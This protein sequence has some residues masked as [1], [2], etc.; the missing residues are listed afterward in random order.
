[1]A[2]QIEIQYNGV[3]Q[4]D[5]DTR[6]ENPLVIGSSA[7][8]DLIETVSVSVYFTSPTYYLGR[9]IGSFNY[10]VDWSNTDVVSL[11]NGYMATHEVT[12]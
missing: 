10:V 2:Y 1:M 4:I 12:P 5:A 11:I 6:I 7:N 8:D 9:Q 3:Y